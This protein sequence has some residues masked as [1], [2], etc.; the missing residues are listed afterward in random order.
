MNWPDNARLT[1]FENGRS[2]RVVTGWRS[3]DAGS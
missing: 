2:C 3:F 1:L